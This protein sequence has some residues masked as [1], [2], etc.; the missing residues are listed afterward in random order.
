MESPINDNDNNSLVANVVHN[1]NYYSNPPPI[2][3]LQIKDFLV[4]HVFK[5][6][7]LKLGDNFHLKMII[8]TSKP[9]YQEEQDILEFK[10]QIDSNH[11]P[12]LTFDETDQKT[13][14]L[15]DGNRF[16][17][18]IVYL[19]LCETKTI[20][21]ATNLPTDHWMAYIFPNKIL[22]DSYAL[23]I[24]DRVHQLIL[25]T[26]FSH[27][28]PSINVHR[29]QPFNTNFCGYWALEFMITY[30]E[31]TL[32]YRRDETYGLVIDDEN[33]DIATYYKKYVKN[34]GYK[35]QKMSEACMQFLSLFV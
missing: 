18:V 20:N 21:P 6:K 4:N 7:N 33:T 27:H 8:F 9:T 13:I 12:H 25:P 30:L 28:I 22:F 17:E 14:P 10:K 24:S 32:A 15:D 2:N 26:W 3:A 34:Y 5:S 16:Q 19:I 1:Y 23:S 31:T 11:A 29:L 35:T